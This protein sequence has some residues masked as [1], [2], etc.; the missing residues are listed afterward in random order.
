MKRTAAFFLTV[1]I[2]TLALCLSA[3][4]GP[5]LPQP[6]GTPQKE[7]AEEPS[8]EAEAVEPEPQEEPAPET[9][10]EDLRYAKGRPVD[11]CS[12]ISYVPENAIEI[13]NVNLTSENGGS[14]GSFIRISG[15][16]DKD[17]QN[18]INSQIREQFNQLTDPSY[19]PPYTGTKVRIKKLGMD[20]PN[21]TYFSASVTGSFANILSVTINGSWNY[22]KP[23]EEYNELNYLYLSEMR[24]LNFDLNTGKQIRLSDLFADDVDAIGY[25]NSIVGDEL[26]KSGD[27]EQPSYWYWYG[28]APVLSGQFSGIKEDQK[29]YINDYD[30]SI[31][32]VFDYNDPEFHTTSYPV[33]IRVPM[34]GVSAMDRRF[35]GEGLFENEEINYRFL[36]PTSDPEAAKELYIYQEGEYPFEGLDVQYSE[37]SEYFDEMTDTQKY[38]ALLNDESRPQ[39]RG[40][41][42]EILYDL[43]LGL[44]PGPDETVQTGYYDGRYFALPEYITGYQSFYSY[45]G[46]IGDFLN[47]SVGSSMSVTDRSDWSSLYSE[48][49]SVGYCF[50]KG[51][52]EPLE[53]EDIFVKGADIG[54]CLRKA[55][56]AN[57][58]SYSYIGETGLNKDSVYAFY[59]E[60]I[61]R[62]VG[63]T[64]ATDTIN[65]YYS[66]DP[67]DV[68][69]RY[70]GDYDNRWAYASSCN[71]AYYRNI[72]CDNLNIFN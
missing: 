48:S 18:S 12:G 52:D 49:S 47:I 57:L 2:L 26:R 31:T 58:I 19:L 46:Y 34:G 10:P 4:A 71:Y 60:M 24:T 70:I 51:G 29:Y 63:F 33:E 13:E 44:D 66:E 56:Y 36:Y 68:A 62:I 54:A 64:L 28:A 69:T 1:F 9:E 72:G 38:Y 39:F 37:S 40:R 5:S 20:E 32:L 6:D 16:K 65:F 61:S 3:C 55:F 53:P 45:C 21:H 17:V 35:S 22:E 43:S 41:F 8:Y 59:D 50:R 30:G 27:A 15:L 14:E 7:P 42:L 23:S 67:A 25:I 11:T